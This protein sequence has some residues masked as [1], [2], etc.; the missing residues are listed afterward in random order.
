MWMPQEASVASCQSPSHRKSQASL[1][2]GRQFL[3]HL[4][5]LLLPFKIHG[6]VAQQVVVPPPASS[7]RSCTRVLRP[8]HFAFHFITN[9]FLFSLLFPPP[10]LCHCSHSL[11]SWFLCRA[12]QIITTATKV[13]QVQKEALRQSEGAQERNSVRCGLRCEGGPT[14][15]FNETQWQQ[16]V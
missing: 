2:T 8:F 9:F 15:T 7:V 12:L 14:W 13:S 5:Q 1:A 4:P 10:S 16:I 6:S 3:L 11:P